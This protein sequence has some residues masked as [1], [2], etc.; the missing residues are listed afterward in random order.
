MHKDLVIEVDNEPE[1][2]PGWRLPSAT[3][4]C[5]LAARPVSATGSVLR[6]TSS[7]PTREATK[8][9]PG[10]VRLAVTR[11]RRTSSST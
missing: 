9:R 11:A 7:C 2:W 6:C 4:A 8:Q 5:N 1:R 10:A 3:P